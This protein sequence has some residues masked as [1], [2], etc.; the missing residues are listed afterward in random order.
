MI[1]IMAPTAWF[2][3]PSLRVTLFPVLNRLEPM[4]LKA[5]VLWCFA[6]AVTLV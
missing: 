5:L 2:N 4:K 3:F 6:N 1:D